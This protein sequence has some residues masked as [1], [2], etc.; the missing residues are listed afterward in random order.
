MRGEPPVAIVL[1]SRAA[2]GFASLA[3]PGALQRG[4]MLSSDGPDNNVFK[5]KPPMVVQRADMDRFLEVL[6]D[7]LRAVR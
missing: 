4:I 2:G 3:L 1:N 7:A 6:D 5:I